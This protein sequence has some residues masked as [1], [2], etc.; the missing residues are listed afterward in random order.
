MLALLLYV[1]V[2]HIVFRNL[3]NN[4]NEVIFVILVISATK[5]RP[6]V[7]EIRWFDAH[8]S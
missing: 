3:T 6:V 4:A 7:V 5:I 8:A 1:S 2:L